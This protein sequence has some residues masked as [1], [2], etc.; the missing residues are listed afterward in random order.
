MKFLFGFFKSLLFQE[1]FIY[2]YCMCVG[3]WLACVS[4]YMLAWWPQRPEEGIGSSG[5]RVTDGSLLLCLLWDSNPD[6]LLELLVL[7]TT[8][9]SH[10]VTNL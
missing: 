1:G 5:T 10:H 7:L 3:V 8:E 4:V 2:F 6:P 9:P